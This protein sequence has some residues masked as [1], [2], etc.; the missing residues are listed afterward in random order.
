MPSGL[1]K[2]HVLAR[3]KRLW[4]CVMLC[5]VIFDSASSNDCMTLSEAILKKKKK[6]AWNRSYI[7]SCCKSEELSA[8]YHF[9]L[10]MIMESNITNWPPAGYV[11]KKDYISVVNLRA[12]FKHDYNSVV[13]LRASFINFRG[14][15][16]D[17][18]QNFWVLHRKSGSVNAFTG[19]L[20]SLI[21]EVR[22]T[23]IKWY[24]CCICCFA[25]TECL[26]PINSKLTS[27]LTNRDYFWYTDIKTNLPD[28]YYLLNV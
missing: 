20:W 21:D 26:S 18:K 4:K 1:C 27:S 11:M 23:H 28:Q 15:W 3:R 9:L 5:A 13:Y 22:H 12:S 7:V 6:R 8:P 16:I 19:F 14:L 2:L 24:F 10:S 17:H 25:L